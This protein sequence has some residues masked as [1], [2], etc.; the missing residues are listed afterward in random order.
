MDEYKYRS[1]YT[2][3]VL[4]EIAR[5]LVDR[6]VSLLGGMGGRK[7]VRCINVNNPYHL[8]MNMRNFE[9]FQYPCNLYYSLAYIRGFPV[10]T[11]DRKKRSSQYEEFTNKWMAA[12]NKGEDTFFV[13][14]NFD[15]EYKVEITGFDFALDFDE[16]CMYDENYNHKYCTKLK[17]NLNKIRIDDKC[18]NCPHY[19]SNFDKLKS[20]VSLLKSAMDMYSVP[21]QLRFTG[22]G[23][24]IIVGDRYLPNL[25][26]LKDKIELCLHLASELKTIFNLTSLDISSIYTPRRIWKIPYSY[27]IKT[28]NIALPLDDYQFE[29]FNFDMVNPNRV[30]YQLFG[31]GLME[32][33]GTKGDF[34]TFINNYMRSILNGKT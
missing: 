21:Y 15:K 24:T 3:K 29:N 34:I 11:F 7:S 25:P 32:R 20:E 9:I 33:T 22:S 27:D 31:R 16:N 23:F 1:Y 30:K 4:D 10:F 17:V 2:K 28:D 8:L 19:K 18:S 6:E 5:Y 26:K 13:K 12:Y 14:E